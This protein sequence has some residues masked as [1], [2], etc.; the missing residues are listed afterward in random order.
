MTSRTQ[1]NRKR[2]T[3]QKKLELMATEQATSML[4][5]IRITKCNICYAIYAMRYIIHDISYATCDILSDQLRAWL[6]E[7]EA[8]VNPATP[9]MPLGM[10]SMRL[11]AERVSRLAIQD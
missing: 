7:G 4:S 9:E 8:D 11:L 1:Q 3:T 10:R 5:D 6:V 2:I